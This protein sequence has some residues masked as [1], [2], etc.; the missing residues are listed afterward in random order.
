[1][2]HPVRTLLLAVS[3]AV[4]GSAADA[5]EPQMRAEELRREREQ[6]GCR[7]DTSAEKPA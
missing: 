1:M 2:R 6:D 4:F 7:V 5:Q 3:L